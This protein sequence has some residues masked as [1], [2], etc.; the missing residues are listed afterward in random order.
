[1]KKNVLIIAAGM[2]V[3]YVFGA[4]AGRE[5]YDALAAR[6]NG[7]WRDPRVARARRDAVRYAREQAPAI[8]AR[9]ESGAKAS[10]TAARDAADR[11]AR[12]AKDVADKTIA[13]TRDLTDRTVT[14]ARDATDKGVT[15]ARD[16]R[17]KTLT[18]AK[19]AAGR[20]VSAAAEAATRVGEA[21]D[22]VLAELDDEDDER[23]S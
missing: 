13:T 11:T 21:R 8:R 2:A 22:S 18:A 23:Q 10:V 19:D 6:V 5:R 7:V 9:A 20:T 15:A 16:A 17:G 12:L 1:M 4:R 14:T 3:G